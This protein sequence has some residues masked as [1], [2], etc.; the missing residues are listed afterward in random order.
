MR[1][2][3]TYR[4]SPVVSCGDLPWAED[5]FHVPFDQIP[6]NKKERT[7]FVEE[8]GYLI[9]H[10]WWKKQYDRCINGYT[11][12]DAIEPG[13]DA[14][15]DG[16]DC[17]WKHNDCWLEDYDIT[18][19]DKS[20]HISGR[21]YFYLNFWWIYGLEQGGKVKKIIHPRFIDI[22]FLFDLRSQN[23]FR[24]ECDSQELKGRQT[25]FSEKLAGM[26]LGYN[27]TFIPASVNLIVAGLQEDAD[28]TMENTVRGLDMMINTQFYIERKRG[29]DSKDTIIS[30]NGS[31]VRSQTAK[32]KPQ[33]LSR[34]APTF[35]LYEEV[36]KGKK[37]WSLEVEKFVRPS[38]HAEGIKTGY[39]IYIGTGGDVEEGVYDLEQRYFK[40]D[41]YNILSFKRRHTQEYNDSFGKVGA[42]TPKWM[43]LITDK[44]GNSLRKESIAKL[45]KDAPTNDEDKY[46]YWSQ[47]PVYDHHIFMTSSGGFFGKD[48]IMQLNKRKIELKNM[49]QLQIERRGRLEPIDPLNLF[50]GV[51]FVDDNDNS[52]ITIIE[53]PEID[54]DGKVYA[55]LYKAGTD[56]YDRD[57]AETSASKGALTIRKMFRQGQDS[58]HFNTYVATIV[59]RPKT[60]EGGAEKF[61]YHTVLACI[62]YGCRNNIEYG[63]NNMRIF[64]YYMKNGFE[65]LLQDR[66]DIAF[67]GQIKKSVVSNRYGT[68]ASLKHQGL[69]ILKNTLT[70]DFIDRMFILAQVEAFSRFILD[71]DYN[72]DITMSAMEA[73]VL[74]KDEQMHV[75]FSISETM[76]NKR[77][78]VRVFQKENGR[79]LQ[80]II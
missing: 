52:W 47:H 43:F 50:K 76:N 53:E 51:R 79:I 28:H 5:L 72:C 36:G 31:Q 27:Y 24:Y 22:D 11:V 48:I 37:G 55:N 42:I 35:V 69:A 40:P 65:V 64:D 73:E 23:M 10:D 59:E 16:I 25:G 74:A 70:P 58:P 32:D 78:G 80:K 68:D 13:G 56:S 41:Y 66:P 6:R 75:V 38:I 39:Q 67:A 33:T 12:E 21:Y 71:K 17:I 46:R 54:K 8:G 57:E 60:S 63:A 44:D 20:V 3:N 18:I 1:L 26:W 34:Y 30:V 14:I 62:Y 61:Y 77:M 49:S 4:F 9:D 29:G 45:E 19:K 7:K 15:R 2:K